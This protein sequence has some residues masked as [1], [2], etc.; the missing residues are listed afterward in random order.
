LSLGAGRF[1]E[2][3]DGHLVWWTEGGDPAGA[4]VLMV[5]GGPGGRSRPEVLAWWQRLP[6]RWIA[7][8]QRGCGQSLPDSRT[9]HNTLDELVDDMERLRVSLSLERWALAG[10]SWGALVSLAYWLRHPHRVNGLHLRS[11]FLGSAEETKRYIGPWLRWLGAAGQVALGEDARRLLLMFHGASAAFDAGS[12]LTRCA[13]PV[14]ADEPRLAD[15]WNRFDDAQAQPGGVAASGA[16]WSPPEDAQPALPGGWRI[17]EHYASRA[18][19]LRRPLRDALAAAG[20]PPATV[21]VTI[22]HGARDACCDPD[23]SEWLAHW[24]AH[25]RCVRIAEGGHRMSQPEMAS[26]LRHSA[27]EWIG[28]LSAATGR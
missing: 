15:A 22:V 10:G 28:R 6:V 13:R 2:P 19:F 11:S 1:L 7:I 3:R 21:P 4:P 8:D 26:A 18:W 23:A 5:H 16:R 27:V 14:W 20:A 12:G 25:A 9:E 24:C 17:F